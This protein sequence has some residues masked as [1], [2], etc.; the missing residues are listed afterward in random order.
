M[1][2][3]MLA[4]LDALG[5]SAAVQTLAAEALRENPA[6]KV[7]FCDI[8]T[9]RAILLAQTLCMRAK[10]KDLAHWRDWTRRNRA[11]MVHFA[12]D[13]SDPL[14]GVMHRLSELYLGF[15]AAPRFV[16]TMLAA[17]PASSREEL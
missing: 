15:R 14:P 1:P 11:S 5:E 12:A 7:V 17:T 6:E 4:Y 8:F 2:L 9:L 16:R 10:L 13:R 3:P